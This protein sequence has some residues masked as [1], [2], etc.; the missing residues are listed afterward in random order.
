MGTTECLGQVLRLSTPHMARGNEGCG[1]LMAA[2]TR[3]LAIEV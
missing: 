1:S 3:A 2:G